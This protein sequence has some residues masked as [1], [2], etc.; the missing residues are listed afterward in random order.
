MGPG[1]QIDP[2][3]PGQIELMYVCG[4]A[5]IDHLQYSV[6]VYFLCHNIVC[7]SGE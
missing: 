4:Y 7:F 3:P 6:F 1:G 2:L 5:Y